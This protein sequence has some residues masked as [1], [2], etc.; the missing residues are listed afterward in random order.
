MK[1]KKAPATEIYKQSIPLGSIIKYYS[2]SEG[3]HKLQQVMLARYEISKGEVGKEWHY[4]LFRLDDGNA[5]GLP[6]TIQGAGECWP[7]PVHDL[8]MVNLVVTEIWVPTLSS[9]KTPPPETEHKDCT[10]TPNCKEKNYVVSSG[11]KTPQI[12]Y[13]KCPHLKLVCT[14]LTGHSGEHHAHGGSECCCSWHDK[15][16]VPKPTS[17]SSWT[18]KPFEVTG[19]IAICGNHTHDDDHSNK[20]PISECNLGG[21]EAHGTW[22]GGDWC[23]AA[24]NVTPGWICNMKKGHVEQGQLIHHAHHDGLCRCSWIDESSLELL[25]QMKDVSFSVI[26]S[27]E[28]L[29]NTEFLEGK[30]EDAKIYPTYKTPHNPK[31]CSLLSV[32][33]NGC[34]NVSCPHTPSLIC[35]MPKGHNSYPHHAHGSDEDKNCLC[36]WPIQ[37]KEQIKELIK[38]T[39]TPDPNCNG[40]VIGPTLGCFKK[41]PH[42]E[43]ICSLKQGHDGN[44]H[45]HSGVS[46]LCVWPAEPKNSHNPIVN[47][48]YL[49]DQGQPYCLKTCPHEPQY[50]CGLSKGHETITKTHHAHSAPYHCLCTWEG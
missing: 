6:L 22:F 17:K 15:D 49:T 26:G 36:I 24:C 38:E 4:D 7:L 42:G 46:C 12:C 40:E 2:S 28:N 21:K 16:E 5:Y 31:T 34:C 30:I 37:I 33:G 47:C 8:N 27:T 44:H 45:A 14:L 20:T 50:V 10:P 35:T 9:T 48:P 41:C 23:G 1:Y 11:Y 43:F 32:T 29:V 19:K 13:K 25:K 3:G 18:N 39:C